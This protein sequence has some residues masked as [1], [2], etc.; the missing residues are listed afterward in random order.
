MWQFELH[1]R[2]ALEHLHLLSEHFPEQSHSI[3][4]SF[5]ALFLFPNLKQTVLRLTD[6]V[7]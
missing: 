4:I 1:L 5:I 6:S 2:L 7:T 3:S